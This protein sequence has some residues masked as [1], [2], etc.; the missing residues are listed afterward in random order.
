MRRT[1][2]V[3]TLTLV[4]ARVRLASL[5]AAAFCASL[6]LAA[7]DA[8]AAGRRVTF[9]YHDAAY[10]WLG[11]TSGGTAFVPDGLPPGERPPL[12]VFFHG[13]NVERTLHFWTG[14]RGEPDLVEV[15]DHVMVSGASLPFVFAAPSQTRGAMSGRHMWQDFDL[16]EFVR[17]V[18]AAIAPRE[19]DHDR[20]ILMGHSGGGC[21]PD[22][23]LM[24]AA[25][26]SRLA[27]WAVLAIDTCMDEEDGTAYADL[28][29]SARIIVRWQPEMWLR[30]V[31][32][33]RA[34]FAAAAELSGHP[35]L[36][37]QVVPGLGP[38]AHEAILVDTF[39]SL[40]PQV[41][42]GKAIAGDR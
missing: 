20:I 34:A 27:P 26:A 6:A 29:E 17:D 16:D 35:D 38:D 2:R 22:G 23:G 24:R 21:N 5:L 36:I 11:E 31:D 41:V 9:P 30:P 33:F 13:V 28:P 14:G 42:A 8:G 18:D 4:L 19:V 37:M 1:A 15:A 32:K 39:T 10:L 12:V 25:R 3:R 7:R 40:L